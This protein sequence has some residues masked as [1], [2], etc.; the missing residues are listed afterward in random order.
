MSASRPRPTRAII[1]AAMLAC[2]VLAGLVL[3]ITIGVPWEQP[4][5]V[6]AQPAGSAEPEAQAAAQGADAAE[7]AAEAGGSA[8]GAEADQGDAAPTGGTAVRAEAVESGQSSGQGASREPEQLTC[9]ISIDCATVLD[10]MDRLDEAKRG[11]IPANGVILAETTMQISEGDTVFDVLVAATQGRIHMEHQY[12]PAY[13]A[14]YVEGINNLYE[15]DC[16]DGSGWMVFVDGERLPVGASSWELHG[17]ER[18]QWRYT[19][20]LGYDL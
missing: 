12:F 9:T 18:I 7:P 16:G 15:F 11:L 3:A 5:E 19:C 13:G 14:E 1:L 8:A 2:V 20:D 6:A 4:A 17:G 10:H